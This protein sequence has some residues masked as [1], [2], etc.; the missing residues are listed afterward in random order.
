MVDAPPTLSLDMGQDLFNV[1]LANTADVDCNTYP[2]KQVHAAAKSAGS[3]WK[4]VCRTAWKEDS[5]SA[6]MGARCLMQR[7]TAALL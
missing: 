2:I 5:T 6:H 1:F 3:L 4:D 7:T